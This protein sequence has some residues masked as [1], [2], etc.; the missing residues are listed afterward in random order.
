MNN[1]ECSSVVSKTNK[2]TGD[3]TECAGFP[4]INRDERVSQWNDLSCNS[5][6]ITMIKA[7]SKRIWY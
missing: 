5:C 4:E 3:F 6:D 1:S 7:T 2:G